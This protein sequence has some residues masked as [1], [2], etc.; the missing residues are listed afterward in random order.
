[1]HAVA[2][3]TAQEDLKGFLPEPLSL[4]LL[5][6]EQIRLCNCNLEHVLIE[7]DLLNLQ[8]IATLSGGERAQH[9]DKEN[10]AFVRSPVNENS[11]LQRDN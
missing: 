6:A 10:K 8:R 2:A 5:V 3:L 9:V 4:P 1:M 7:I 11:L